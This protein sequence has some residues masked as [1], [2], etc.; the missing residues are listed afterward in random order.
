MNILYRKIWFPSCFKLIY[1]VLFVELNKATQ[2][3]RLWKRLQI[4]KTPT[5]KN[6]KNINIIGNCIYQVQID[7][8]QQI[9]YWRCEKHKHCQ[10]PSK[11]LLLCHL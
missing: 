4:N 6:R 7:I 11:T 2:Q 3:K 8:H 5:H 1:M 9:L 10:P